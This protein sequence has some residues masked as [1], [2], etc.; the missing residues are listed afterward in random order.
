M[1]DLFGGLGGFMKGLTN[2]MPKDDPNTQLVK[3]QAEVSELRKQKEDMYTEIGKAAIEAHGLDSFGPLANKMRLIDANL[4]EAEQRLADAQGEAEAKERAEKEALAGR[5]CPSCG[6]ENPEGTRFC[7]ECGAKLGAQKNMCPSCGSENDA[8]VKFCNQCG[9]R[10]QQAT[11]AY[12]PACGHENPPG[13]RFCGG[14]GAKL[15]G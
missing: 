10:L 1:A 11:P 4:A 12:C 6:H 8:G 9:T 2:L 14:C 7:Q 13:T 3:L 15:E 5:T